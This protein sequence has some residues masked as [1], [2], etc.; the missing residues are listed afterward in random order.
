[1]N[2]GLNS[3]T[4][5]FLQCCKVYSVCNLEYTVYPK[6]FIDLQKQLSFD[7]RWKK[8]GDCSKAIKIIYRYFTLNL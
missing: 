6:I 7:L 2:P 3:K 8:S 5:V 4:T 1:M